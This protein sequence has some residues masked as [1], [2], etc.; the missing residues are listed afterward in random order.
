MNLATIYSMP[1]Y[2]AVTSIAPDSSANSFLAP[3]YVSGGFNSEMHSRIEKTCL[4]WDGLFFRTISLFH[5][6]GLSWRNCNSNGRRN[7]FLVNSRVQSHHADVPAAKEL[8]RLL[9]AMRL[10]W[11]GDGLIE[12]LVQVV[13][14]PG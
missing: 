7:R 3:E 5:S 9:E 14:L 6:S 8:W 10:Q 12:P 13:S 4:S 2:N 1:S 11:W